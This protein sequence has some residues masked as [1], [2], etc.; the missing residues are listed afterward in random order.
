MG[1]VLHHN[2]RAGAD[3]QRYVAAAESLGAPIAPAYHFIGAG[4]VP[5][6][7]RRTTTARPARP[8]RLPSAVGGVG[9]MP[10]K[11][12]NARAPAAKQNKKHEED[13]GGLV[14]DILA[15]VNEVLGARL[16]RLTGAERDAEM[17]TA[18]SLMAAVIG[19]LSTRAAELEHEQ[20][21]RQAERAKKPRLQQAILAAAKHH[22]GHNKI[23][24]KAW[25]LIKKTPFQ[26]S[27]ETV[28]IEGGMMLVQQ[29]DGT[30]RRGGIK[31][32]QWQKRYWPAAKSS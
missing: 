15:A 2:A 31:E 23:A 10:S 9:L 6:V 16:A 27:G 8:V 14:R 24:K 7:A 18:S 29:R 5:A 30:R 32:P 1:D 13:V 21:E 25:D 11:R 17:R 19:A 26:T 3:A 20:R 12:R 4:P 28:M 22:R